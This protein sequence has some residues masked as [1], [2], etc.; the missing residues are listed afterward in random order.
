MLTIK[1]KEL[2][3]SNYLKRKIEMTCKFAGVKVEIT[4]GSIKSIDKT[5][6]AYVVPHQIL[7]NGIN[8]LMFDESNIVF[9]NN[10][11][12][13]IEF[14]EFEEHIKKFLSRGIDL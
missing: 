8:Y 9:I 3:I 12:Q 11:N 5:N 14:K 10:F 7:I 6:V 13:Q 4:N 1:T 2:V